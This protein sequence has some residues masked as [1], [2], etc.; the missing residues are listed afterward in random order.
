MSQE[1]KRIIVGVCAIC[2]IPALLA[3]TK[4]LVPDHNHKTKVIRG[5]L[6]EACNGRL[7]YYERHKNW[8]HPWVR[9][10]RPKIESHLHSNSGFKWPQRGKY[11][12]HV[13]ELHGSVATQPRPTSVEARLPHV[14]QPT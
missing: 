9:D 12:K 5:L 6:C 1:S 11:R 4:K 10:Y 8:D 2:G 3:N 13:R 7:G 14:P